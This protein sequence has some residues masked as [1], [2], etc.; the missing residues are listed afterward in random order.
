MKLIKLTFLLSFMLI[1]FGCGK[2]DK[3]V[4]ESSRNNDLVEMKSSADDK[5]AQELSE[6]KG[7]AII[8]FWASWCMPC[9]EM[10]PIFESLEEEYAGKLEFISVDIDNE[11]ALSD[12]YGIEAIPTFIFIN[13]EGQE[14]N[15]I[16]GS[17]PES[18]LREAI[19]KIAK[20]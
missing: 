16:V 7:P 13:S 8:D 3:S 2:N 10:K 4:S 14:V 15:R 17:V 6:T 11:K 18:E 19:E 20:K 9:M 5:D 12:K 1:L